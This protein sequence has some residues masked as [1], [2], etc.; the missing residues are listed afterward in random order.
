MNPQ[1]Y[2]SVACYLGI[3]DQLNN[4]HNE[5][6]IKHMINYDEL[7]RCFSPTRKIVNE[8]FT[9]DIIDRYYVLDGGERRGRFSTVKFGNFFNLFELIF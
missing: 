6:Q 4:I 7:R 5:D 3:S 8:N 2:F 1:Q 9:D